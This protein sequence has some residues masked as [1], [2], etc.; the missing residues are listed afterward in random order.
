MPTRIRNKNL[1]A[2]IIS[3]G[4]ALEPPIKLEWLHRA[5]ETAENPYMLLKPEQQERLRAWEGQYAETD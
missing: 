5:F 4:G 1:A 2:L 3:L